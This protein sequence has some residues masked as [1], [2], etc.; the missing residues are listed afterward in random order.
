MKKFRRVLSILC[1]SLVLLLVSCNDNEEERMGVLKLTFKRINYFGGYTTNE[2]L[3]FENNQF[4]K[5]G[6]TPEYEEEPELEV[7]REF[8]EEEEK[9]FID[10]CYDNGLF[11]IDELYA[12]YDFIDGGEWQLIVEFSDGTIKTSRGINETPTIVF[13]KCST[14]F[15]DICREEILGTL[16]SYYY[17]APNVDFD[18]YCKSDS[19]NIH[20]SA[21]KYNYIWNKFSEENINLYELNEK[22][23]ADYFSTDKEYKLILETTN[24]RCN[25]KFTSITI[26]SYDYNQELSNEEI[27]YNDIWFKRIEIDLELNKIY[28]Y[29]L[30][31]EDGDYAQYTFNTKVI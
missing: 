31:F 12:N 25:E 21:K 8:T 7:R 15:Y 19:K 28:V 22:N 10:G 18:C 11:K 9:Y 13:N 5:N 1:I 2:V 4:L 16:P 26:K 30:T 20:N 14:Y 3:D 29:E 23:S 27:V 17:E 24:Y 6:Y